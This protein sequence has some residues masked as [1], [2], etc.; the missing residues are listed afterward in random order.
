M[1]LGCFSLVNITGL[2]FEADSFEHLCNALAFWQVY[3]LADPH[4]L[5]V[6]YLYYCQQSY[7][8]SV[9]TQSFVA[10]TFINGYSV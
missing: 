1:D 4:F 10:F 6:A 9:L 5:H 8:E 7:E 2:G 3:W